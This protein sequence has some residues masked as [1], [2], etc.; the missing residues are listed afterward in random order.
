MIKPVITKEM[1]QSLWD[2]SETAT[3]YDLVSDRPSDAKA[4]LTWAD[5]TPSGFAVRDI[6]P[7]DAVMTVTI[8]VP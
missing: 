3:G 2:G 5:G 6:P 4:A 1:E 7:S 8:D